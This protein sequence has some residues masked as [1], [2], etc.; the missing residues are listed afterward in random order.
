MKRHYS[1][2]LLKTLNKIEAD[3]EGLDYVSMWK[4]VALVVKHN[5]ID[6]L[7]TM[8]TVCQNNPNTLK[9]CLNYKG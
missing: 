5:D 1:K 3:G 9:A 4:I 7:N 6:A 8:L 2:K